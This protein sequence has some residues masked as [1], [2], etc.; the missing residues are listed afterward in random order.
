MP[1]FTTAQRTA[2]LTN[3]PQMA[4]SA[5]QRAALAIEGFTTELDFLDFDHDALKQSFKNTRS[6]VPAVPIPAKSTM[7]L[8]VASTA[9][10]YYTDTARDVTTVNMHYNNVLRAFKL[11][12]DAIT[13]M[14]NKANDLKLPVLSKNCPPLK[15]CESMKHYL[16]NTFGVRKIPL[17]YIIRDDVAVA[18]EAPPAGQIP[19]PSVT[20]DPLVTDMAYGNSGTVLGDMIDRASHTHVLYKT[21]NAQV[22]SLIEQAARNSSFLSTIKSFEKRKNGRGAWLAL[23]TAHVG[24]SK[25]EQIL[26]DNSKWLINSR[27]NGK[28]YAL[29]SFMAQHRQKFEQMKEAS[30]HVTFQVPTEHTRVGYILDGI[31]TDSPALHAAI[32][33]VRNDK[34]GARQDFDAAI[35]ILVPSDPFAKQEALKTSKS[36]QFNIASATGSDTKQN[37]NN[38]RGGKTNVDLRWHTAQEFA[39]LSRDEKSELSAWQRTAEGKKATSDARSSH[40]KTKKRQSNNNGNKSSKKLKARIYALEKEKNDR[41]KETEDTTK[42]SQIAAALSRSSQPNQGSRTTGGQE[43]STLAREIM[44][45]MAR[46]DTTNK[47]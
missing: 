31:E 32:A 5:D 45:I 27:W 38:G 29:E 33:T 37:N 10:H 21:D 44:G 23:I 40:F 36:V 34:D 41:D 18:P 24:D 46:N 6:H 16:Y 7:R 28:K 22:Y 13:S 9:Y 14:S 15:W 3:N 30:L 47:K 19:D 20:Y 35:A 4:L 1:A 12:W 39:A 26:N 43:H 8:L 42:V 2:F 11:E 17:T 25:W